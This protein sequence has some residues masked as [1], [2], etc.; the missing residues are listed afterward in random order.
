[1]IQPYYK[2]FGAVNDTVVNGYRIVF[3]DLTPYP[4]LTKPENAGLSKIATIEITH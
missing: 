3:K 1:M 4:D 2:N